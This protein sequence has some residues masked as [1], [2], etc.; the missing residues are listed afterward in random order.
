MNFITD[1]DEATQTVKNLSLIVK[2]MEFPSNPPIKIIAMGACYNGLVEYLDLS[3]TTVQE[4]QYDAFYSCFFLT[5][6]H[7]PNTLQTFGYNSFF[8]TSLTQI[9]LPAS[10]ETMTGFA[11]NQSPF[12]ES[13]EVDS[14]NKVFS[15]ECGF[16]YNYDKT[17]LICA[18]RYITYASDIHLIN[19]L[20]TI[21]EYA[22]TT[23][24]LITFV[25][26]KTIN[27]IETRAFH[28][29]YLLTSIDLSLSNISSLCYLLFNGCI[30]V[31]TILLP[32]N[33]RHIPTNSIVSMPS[34]RVIYIYPY[35]EEIQEKSIVDCQMLKAICY[36]G[37]RDFS[38]IEII[39]G[40]QSENTQVFVTF[41]Y[42]TTLFGKLPVFVKKFGFI[43]SSVNQQT[44]LQN[45][46]ISFLFI[47]L[48]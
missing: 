3:Q 40:R 44:T 29:V 42:P 17:S 8:N 1:Y 7:F 4:I 36:Y 19:Q 31:H 2:R 35:V 45:A 9:R 33:L 39:S 47:I 18:P 26:P 25:A 43:K 22:F 24:N 46:L 11:W 21:G 13:F 5:E 15:S 48:N 28:C 38:D 10:V 20:T 32:S 37:N 14:S 12:I 6:V 30:S 23:T 34:L 41:M 16:L 27:V